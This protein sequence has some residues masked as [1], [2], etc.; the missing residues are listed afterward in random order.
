MIKYPS[1]QLLTSFA[2][3]Q[4]IPQIPTLKAH[5]ADDVFKLWDAWEKESSGECEIPFW[6]VVWPAAISL[7]KYLSNNPSLVQDKSVLDFGCGGGLV[8]IAAKKI[9]AQTVC[10]VDIDPVALHVAKR[11]MKE[12]NTNI[13]FSSENLLSDGREIPFYD[14]LC[15]ADMFYERS[16]SKQ[17]MDFIVAQKKRGTAI[18]VAD[19]GRAYAPKECEK[20]LYEETLPVNKELEG[21]TERQVRIISL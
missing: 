9:G 2:P 16:N 1:E 5:I 21:V 14:L 15:I 4:A 19:G 6:A 7:V 13:D 12:N 11:N 17:L 20:I 10:G 18:L 8:G 3:I